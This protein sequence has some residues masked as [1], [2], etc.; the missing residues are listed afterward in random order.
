MLKNIWLKTLFEKRWS[1]LF[2]SILAFYVSF[3]LT[4]IFPSIKDMMAG[5]ISNPQMSEG[6]LSG[7][8]GPGTDWTSMSGYIAMEIFGEGALLPAM[9]IAFFGASFLAGDENKNILQVLLLQPVSRTKIYFQKFLALIIILV[10]LMI[11]YVVG[12]IAGIAVIGEQIPWMAIL[13]GSL[14][15]LLFS[16]SLGVISFA[17]SAA[18]GKNALSAGLIMGYAFLGYMLANLTGISEIVDRV[19]N[20][21]IYKYVDAATVVKDGLDITNIGIFCGIIVIFLI[22]GLLIFRRRNIAF[23]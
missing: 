15:V 2:L 20:F 12:T 1:L 7:W 3:L 16:A 17:I 5:I 21:A 10:I 4:L 6:A 19:S 22:L 9:V 23:K 11:F 8:F 18:T 14:M 13:D